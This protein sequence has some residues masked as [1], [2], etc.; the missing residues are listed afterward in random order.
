M[1]KNNLYFYGL[2]FALILFA[3]LPIFLIE[4]GRLVEVETYSV[5]ME[6]TEKTI[7]QPENA[8]IFSLEGSGE[9]VRLKVS[10]S[11]YVRY[12]TG[13]ILEILITVKETKFTHTQFKFYEILGRCGE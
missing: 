5:G 2:I 1:K 12:D 8:K 9:Q 6:V 3:L 7:Q 10:N 11:N 13:E 4:D